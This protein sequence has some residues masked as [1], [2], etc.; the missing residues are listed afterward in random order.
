MYCYECTMPYES[1]TKF[2]EE[3]EWKLKAKSPVV[4]FGRDLLHLPKLKFKESVYDQAYESG[5]EYR[6]EQGNGGGIQVVY[7]QPSLRLFVYYSAN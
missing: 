2:A 6:K 7:H 1:A 4:L 5:L 3:Q